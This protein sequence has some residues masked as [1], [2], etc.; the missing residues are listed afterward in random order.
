M[1]LLFVDACHIKNEYNG[2]I[3]AACSIDG[4]GQLVPIAY[5]IADIENNTNWNWFMDNLQNSNEIIME[6]KISFISDQEKGI[7]NATSEV[8]PGCQQCFCVKHMEKNV[9]KIV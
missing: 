9:K 6:N 7:I 2:I 1:P 3:L 8:F 4:N 5:G